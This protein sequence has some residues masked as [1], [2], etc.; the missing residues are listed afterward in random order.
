LSICCTVERRRR[1][2]A[3]L[4]QWHDIVV[5][6]RPGCEL[7]TLTPD[8]ALKRDNFGEMSDYQCRTAKLLAVPGCFLAA[9]LRKKRGFARQTRPA[10]CF[11]TVFNSDISGRRL[12]ALCGGP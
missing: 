8:E 5:L 4:P 3:K 10:G 9:A 1:T 12:L 6:C 11:F 7:V 2:I